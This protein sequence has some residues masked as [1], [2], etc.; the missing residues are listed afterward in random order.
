MLQQM[1][2]KAKASGGGGS[3]S[4]SGNMGFLSSVQLC[5]FF[6]K[7]SQMASESLLLKER[8]HPLSIQTF[9]GCCDEVV[10][11]RKTMLVAIGKCNAAVDLHDE[12][13]ICS[14]LAILN[15]AI[16]L[17]IETT[18][19]AVYQVAE[20]SPGCRKADPG[21]IDVYLLARG[22]LAIEIAT[23]GFSRASITGEQVMSIAAVV[24]THLEV[25]RD[26]CL[27]A[28]SKT[29]G[30]D[31]KQSMVFDSLARGLSGNAAMLVATIKAFVAAPSAINRKAAETLSKPLLA[32]IDAVIAIGTSEPRFVGTAPVMTRDVADY[33]KPIQ[34]AGL[35]VASAATL[36]VTALK[37]R[38]TQPENRDAPLAMKRY[39]T[40]ID[41]ALSELVK[42]MRGCRD[43]G[44]IYEDP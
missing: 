15:E 20:K 44:L 9:S 42:A 39:A 6:V 28:A 29:K 27:K 33:V 31:P 22:K 40:S 35:S 8:D 1:G 13:G 30:G 25:L 43:S 17:I 36:F 18:A 24:A 12:A 32:C 41:S 21:V 37:T 23:G 3:A 2:G 14:A 7:T 16:S 5:A 38:L 26:Q 11:K 10:A 19:Q 4:D 34:A